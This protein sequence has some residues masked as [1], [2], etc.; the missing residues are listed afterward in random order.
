MNN[1]MQL[2]MMI[3]NSNNPMGMIQQ[4]FGNNPQYSQI[5]SMIQGKSPQQ[6]EQYVRNLYQSQGQDINQIASQFG[7]KI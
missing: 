5:M 6:I 7:L 4:M 2:M 1:P 3:R